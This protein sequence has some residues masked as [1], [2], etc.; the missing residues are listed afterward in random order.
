MEGEE[1]LLSRVEQGG[2]FLLVYG[3]V[4]GPCVGL[5]GVSAEL[6]ASVMIFA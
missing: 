4:E 2:S 1:G 5:C 6:F 3:S